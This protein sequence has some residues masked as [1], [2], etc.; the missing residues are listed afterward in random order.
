MLSAAAKHRQPADTVEALRL[1]ACVAA[2]L[3]SFAIKA[4]LVVQQN[5][6][7]S[8]VAKSV[9]E[10]YKVNLT[11]PHIKSLLLEIAGSSVA[12]Q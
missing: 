7:N 4:S 3:Q 1:A 9:R 8:A 12:Q 11:G 2:C 6:I 5:E 10:S